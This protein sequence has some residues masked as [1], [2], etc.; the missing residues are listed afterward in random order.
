M[1]GKRLEERKRVPQR[2]HP[3]TAHLFLFKSIDLFLFFSS[4]FEPN[5]EG[6]LKVTRPV[7][8]FS[9][10]KEFISESYVVLF[11]INLKH[12]SYDRHDRAEK[13]SGS[14]RHHF[15]RVLY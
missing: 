11:A 3:S 14:I 15:S 13:I 8:R 7:L 6:G 5:S 2:K 4:S 1:Q 12:R 9:I 10:S